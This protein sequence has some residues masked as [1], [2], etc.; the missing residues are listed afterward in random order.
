MAERPPKIELIPK[1]AVEERAPRE[2]DAAV[3]MPSA[4]MR[5]DLPSE[6]NASLP[7]IAPRR[8]YAPPKLGAPIPGKVKMVEPA[9]PMVAQWLSSVV[10]ALR[11]MNMYADNNAR[12]KDFIDQSFS[13]LEDIFEKASRID[14]VIDG[15]HIAYG[16]DLV[17]YNPEPFES[18][19]RLLYEGSVRKLILTRGLTV[20]ELV[21]FFSVI[22]TDFSRPENFGDDLVA[23]FGRMSLPHL[24]AK[25][26]ETPAVVPPKYVAPVEPDPLPSPSPV[27]SP[28]VLPRLSSAYFEPIAEEDDEATVLGQPPPRQRPPSNDFASTDDLVTEQRESIEDVA[29]LHRAFMEDDPSQE[30]TADGESD[31]PLEKTADDEATVQKKKPSDLASMEDEATLQEGTTAPKID[32]SDLLGDE[33]G[34]TKR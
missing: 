32:V 2:G 5:V 29:T 23:I 24:R 21:R 34:S 7:A 3:R 17:H 31:S 16:R 1:A 12:R 8:A 6:S 18:L 11:G 13:L 30:K 20:L 19:P 9:S 25:G 10:R 22:S 27:P 14:L 4:V 33:R 28:E 15:D 26:P